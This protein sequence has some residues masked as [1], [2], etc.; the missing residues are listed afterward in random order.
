MVSRESG[1]GRH[2][3]KYCVISR[4]EL[5]LNCCNMDVLGYKQFK[6]FYLL[7]AQTGKSERCEVKI[8]VLK[9]PAI[10]I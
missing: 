6:T 1:R 2:T 5:Q 10:Y 7:K 8:I 4:T 3:F 9:N